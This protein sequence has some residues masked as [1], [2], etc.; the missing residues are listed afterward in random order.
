MSNYS[1]K[2]I[3]D[4][5]T[6]KREW[7][8]QF[9]V[10]YYLFRPLSFPIAFIVLKLTSSPAKVAWTGFLIGLSGCVALSFSSELS[11]WTGVILLFLCS[12]SDAVDGNV[13][14]TTKQVTRYGKYLDGIL[15]AVVEGGYGFFLGLGLFRDT[16]STSLLVAGSLMSLGWFLSS[17]IVESYAKLLNEKEHTTQEVTAVIGSS[18]YRRFFLYRV[19]MNLHAVNLQLL[20]LVVALTLNLA[21]LFLWMMVAYYAVRTFVFFS[22]YL[23]R[24]RTTLT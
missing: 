5:Y 2:D 10:S 3:K 11:V 17:C 12:L 24:G 13:A 4:S 15:G 6:Q 19:F 20:I 14:R 8:K 23:W 16:G 1:Y 9:P 21:S 22:F 18:T 7:E